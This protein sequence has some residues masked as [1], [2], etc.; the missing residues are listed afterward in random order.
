MRETRGRARL[1]L[2]VP[3]TN[4][5]FEP[6][7]ALMCPPGL[8]LHVA[9]M[10]GYDEDEIPDE[11]QMQGLGGSDLSEPLALLM[12]AK[13]DV[14]LYG[15]TSATLTH[16]PAFD[17]ALT[18]QI[19]RQSGAQT[20]T[21]AGALVAALR[22]LGARRIGFASPY[23]PAINDLAINFLKSEGFE[24]VHRSDFDGTL[25]NEG[26][27][28]LMPDDVYALGLRADHPNADAIVLSCTDMRAVETVA[29]LEAT[30]GKPVIS[31]NQA[32][33]F[34]TLTALEIREPVQ[35]FGQL[36]DGCAPGMR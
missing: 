34:A 32:L 16:G 6:D 20:V 5:N 21:A 13:P 4:T 18:E 14:V 8:S 24:T 26:Q 22:H 29:R 7:M 17:T 9:R 19:R 27:G 28:A 36:L 1:G 23:V 31:S 30:L 35:G 12:G 25:D 10:G 2:L 33:M 11:H 15:C 3:F